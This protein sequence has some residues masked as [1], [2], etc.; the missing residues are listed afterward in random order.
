MADLA[1][2]RFA[3][4]ATRHAYEAALRE[5]RTAEVRA[6][7]HREPDGSFPVVDQT[8]NHELFAEL[9][10]LQP[11]L[12]AATA[13]LDAARAEFD[14]AVATYDAAARQA[15][16]FDADNADPVLLLPVRIEAVYVDLVGASELR[17]RVYPDDVHVDDHEPALTEGERSAGIAYWRAVRAAGADGAKRAA[18][19]Q[20][21]VG[22]CGGGRAA[23]VRD[24]LTPVGGPAGEPAFPEV[25]LR[26]EAWTRAAHTQLLPDHFEFSAY[27]D[28]A[29]V[30]RRTG[31]PIADT[32]AVG[33]APQPGDGAAEPDALAF[34]DASR[35]LVDFRLAEAAGMALVAPLADPGERFDLL[36]VVGIGT[37][38]GATGA[39]RVQQ[40][41]TAHAHSGGLTPLPVGTPTN[42]T[43][44]TRSGWRSRATPPDPEV[45]ATW[46][47]AFDADGDQEAAR[48]ARALGVDGSVV[49]AGVC[50]PAGGDEA[51]LRRLHGLQ[52]DFYSRSPALWEVK[53]GEAQVTPDPPPWYRTVAEHYTKFVRS[54]GPLPPLRIGRQPYGLL[55]VEFD[56]P[57][58]WRRRRHGDK[59][60]RRLVPERLR[61]SRRPRSADRRGGR[62]GRGAARPVEPGGQ[63]AAAGGAGVLWL[64]SD[65]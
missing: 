6:D 42:N 10:A 49:L 65:G 9:A 40:M 34:D 15:P 8:L 2:E 13:A 1:A 35:W 11:A 48:L 19:W 56:R 17:I 47:A 62:S 16:L 32:L 12:D 27:R 46:R 3:V 29:L 44:G 26:P 23:W 45:V 59:P 7:Y 30:W 38:D 63:P 57:L 20:A 14:Q 5:L 21:L 24:S 64:R 25:E 58:A 51:L 39:A 28:G 41:L 33:I 43:P 54:R 22:V 18:A 36:T 53:N 55:P 52:A 61:H 50:D 37:Q 60:V 31:A 4:A